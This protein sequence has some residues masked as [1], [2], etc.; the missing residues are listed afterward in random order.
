MRPIRGDDGTAVFRAVVRVFLAV[1]LPVISAPVYAQRN[2]PDLSAN[3]EID[4]ATGAF[5]A[6]AVLEAPQ[7]D[8]VLPG[9]EWLV[10]D[11]V[12]LVTGG[13]DL[14]DAV[15]DGTL[16]AEAHRNMDLRGSVSGQLPAPQQPPAAVA[17]STEA[18]YLVGA[19][20]FPVDD[21]E[22]R[23][24]DITVTV[25]ASQRVAA[26]GTLLSDAVTDGRRETRHVFTGRARDVGLFLGPYV[27]DETVH[28][29]LELRT[30]FEQ[31]DADLSGRY[32]EALARYLDRYESEVGDYPYGGFSVVSAPIPVG[33][34]FAGLTYVSG[35]IL[36][37]PY[38][39]GRSLAHE[40]LHSWWGNA[41]GVDFDTGNWAEGLTTFQADYALAEDRGDEAARDM[42]IGW[43]RDL[44]RLSDAQMRPLAAFRASS[45]AG[46]Q[47]EGYG[48]AALVFHML[49]DEVGPGPFGAGIR[50]FYDRNRNRIAGWADLRAAFEEGAGREL[51]WFFDQWISRA[52]LPRVEIVEAALRETADGTVA[53]LS[54]RQESPAYR[55]RVPLVFALPS[56]P[57]HRI[58]ELSE[59][60]ESVDILLAARPRTVRLDPDFDL[61]R[62]PLDGE[63]AP[64]LR[65][66]GARARSGRSP[67]RRSAH[68]PMPSPRSSARRPACRGFPGSPPERARATTARLRS[69]PGL[70]TTWRPSDRRIW[71]PSRRLPAKAGHGFGWSVTAK[72]VSGCS[73]PSRTPRRWGRICRRCATTPARATSPS[74]TGAPSTSGSGRPR[75]GPAHFGLRRPVSAPEDLNSRTARPARARG[76]RR[77]AGGTR[78]RR[79]RC[80]LDKRYCHVNRVVNAVA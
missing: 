11:D 66:V 63:L 40:V 14:A 39:T 12:E 4:A 45:H 71:G 10:I 79:W 59:E 5:V 23:D 20:W 61:A 46:D 62:R 1:A 38:M 29:D 43:I 19:A 37:H 8:V 69:L 25:S 58:V 16:G 7:G 47:S 67:P 52:G 70:P 31:A 15:K 9:A 51:G 74:R 32:F 77:A 26:T 6:E 3:V 33:L 64:I 22:I 18:T 28:G 72:A 13:E 24:H 2:A 36:A 60:R 57:E 55:L 17:W 48:K 44:A 73:C 27:P 21:V 78:L 34:G 50:G 76:S 49:R 56:G 41:V 80:H 68:G 65:S 30:Y 42:R 35:D 54:L 75:T 53:S